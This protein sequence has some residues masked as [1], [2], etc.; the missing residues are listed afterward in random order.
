MK[1]LLTNA[2]LIAAILFIAGCSEK[3]PASTLE[4][5]EILH[6]NQNLLTEVIIYDIFT[7]PVASSIYA[8]T[9]LAS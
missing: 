7:P 9:S 6:L 4:D 8:Y 2:S 5:T 1:K 3:K